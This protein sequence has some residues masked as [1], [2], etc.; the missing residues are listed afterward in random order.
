M[1]IRHTTI[2]LLG[3]VVVVT[4]AGCTSG[5]AP[6]V[7]NSSVKTELSAWS[8]PCNLGVEREESGPGWT[9]IYDL[10]TLAEQTD[11]DLYG[12][13]IANDACTDAQILRWQDVQR[14]SGQSDAIC[15]VIWS[16]DS[17]GLIR[18]LGC[19]VPVVVAER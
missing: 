12:G 3:L 10:P 6:D 14:Q 11:L 17:D 16:H 5:T 18:D 2:A 8:A 13:T 19:A 15:R 1:N 9:A 4:T 7:A